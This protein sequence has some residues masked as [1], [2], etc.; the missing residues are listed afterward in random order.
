VRVADGVDQEALIRRIDA[1]PRW[2]LEASRESEY[3]AKQSESA[4]SLY[5]IV[6]GLAILAGIGATFGATNTLYAAVQSRRAEIGTLRAL[7][8]S[9]ASIL[10]SF[11]VES[12]CVAVGGLVVGAAVAALL[13]RILSSLLGGIGFGSTTFSTSVIELRVG[14]GDLVAAAVLAG[15][16]GVFGGL[17]PA[18]RAARLRP[19]EALRK[20]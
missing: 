18:L 9:K 19:I 20:A 1:D 17:A 10:F 13:G 7:G 14:A 15:L 4:N 5:L 2:A 3:Y 11:L 6:F 8:F 12:L 16:I